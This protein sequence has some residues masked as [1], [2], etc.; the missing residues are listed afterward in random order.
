MVS[1]LCQFRAM[2]CMHLGKVR[3][4]KVL[5]FSLS[6]WNLLPTSVTVLWC[7]CYQLAVSI[8]FREQLSVSNS[9]LNFFFCLVLFRHHHNG[10]WEA[11]IG[12]VLGNKYLYLGTFGTYSFI[13]SFMLFA[14]LSWS[15]L[16]LIKC[17]LLALTSRSC[18]LENLPAVS[19]LPNLHQI[20]WWLINPSAKLNG[21]FFLFPFDVDLTPCFSWGL[22]TR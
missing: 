3:T 16:T 18:L 6:W 10:R 9:F 15:P 1:F 19:R 21:V 22:L 8:L 12:R 7:Q 20:L 4:A 2:S 17:W 5:S 11:R 14:L 13:Q